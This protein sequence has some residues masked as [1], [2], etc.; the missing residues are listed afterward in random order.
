MRLSERAATALPGWTI[1][2]L[3]Y[4][5][6]EGDLCTL[7]KETLRD[8]TQF[9]LPFGESESGIGRL[10]IFLVTSSPHLFPAARSS[11]QQPAVARSSPQNTPAVSSSTNSPLQPSAALSSPGQSLAAPSSHAAPK[12]P[13]SPQ[14]PPVASSSC[15]QSQ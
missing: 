5:D 1:Q 3:A 7:C 9:V 2:R 10:E 14:R 11:P 8:A 12:S 13:G 4:R 15:Q 6:D